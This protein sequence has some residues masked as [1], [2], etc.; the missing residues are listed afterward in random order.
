MKQYRIG[1]FARYLGVTP[2]LLKHYE[3][4][5][6]LRPERTESG[7]R[8]YPFHTTALLIEC[9]RL[10]NYGMTLREIRE[11]LIRRSVESAQVEK[12]LSDNVSHLRQEAL[13]DTLLAEDYDAFL[14]WR[15]PLET[16]EYDWDIRWSRPML[17]LPHTDGYDF[18]EDGRI[19][20]LLKDWM[21]YIPIVKS[22]MKVERSGRVSWGFA[23][24]EDTL[25]RLQLPVNAVVER[26]PP[27]KVFYYKFRSSLAL[28]QV[29]GID[30]ETHPAFRLMRSMNIV[31]GDVYY[32]TTLLPAA[33]EQGIQCQ[34]GYY[35]IPIRAVDGEGGA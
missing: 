4:V 21:S 16:A 11:I 33:W 10:R 7:Y 6:L 20:E 26:V 24:P 9:V 5:G 12:R 18:L 14:S 3:E 15:T 31:P 17:F 28:L 19:Y 13:L 23:V 8:Y 32:R 2:D 34:Y 25:E 30:A 27:Q 22:S 35:A 1:D 29:E